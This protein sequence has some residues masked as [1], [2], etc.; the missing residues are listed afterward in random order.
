MTRESAI[1]INAMVGTMVK[2]IQDE[3][4]WPD[5]P[6]SI[7]MALAKIDELRDEIAQFLL[8]EIEEE[9]S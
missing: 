5:Q 9:K 1:W 3:F 8:R 7:T 2:I 6:P 4:S